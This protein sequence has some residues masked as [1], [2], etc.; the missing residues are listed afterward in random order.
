VGL[1]RGGGASGLRAQSRTCARGCSAQVP[2]STGAKKILQ[3]W[4]MGCGAGR[5]CARKGEPDP[6]NGLA[7]VQRHDALAAFGATCYDALA[8]IA[9]SAYR[10]NRSYETLG[11][12]LA[13]WL[14]SPQRL[15]VTA[16]EFDSDAAH[17]STRTPARPTN[18]SRSNALRHTCRAA[19]IGGVCSRPV[20]G[21]A[22]RANGQRRAS[23]WIRLR[24]RRFQRTGCDE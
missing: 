23:L 7:Q 1:R 20:V 6:W 5:L 16:R 10:Y 22:H 9:A 15:C 17:T 14:A 18:R 13:P 11:I 3:K 21:R 24:V 8:G 19:V 12:A 4:K 2:V